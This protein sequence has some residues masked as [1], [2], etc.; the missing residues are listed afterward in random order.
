MKDKMLDMTPQL[1]G[2]KLIGA[3][4]SVA[5]LDFAFI[6]VL[7]STAQPSPTNRLIG[8]NCLEFAWDLS[9]VQHLEIM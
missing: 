4:I 8:E 3:A 6:Y 7:H 5:I 2:N 1:S 9:L